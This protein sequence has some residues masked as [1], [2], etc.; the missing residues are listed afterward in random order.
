MFFSCWHTIQ[1]NTKKSLLLHNSERM[2]SSAIDIKRAYFWD[3]CCKL[4]HK[5][6]KI[7]FSM[8]WSNN[9]VKK[10]KK[11]KKTVI[12][13]FQINEIPAGLLWRRNEIH[14][15]PFLLKTFWE[16]FL[17]ASEYFKK[18]II[19]PPPK[20]KF[21]VVSEIFLIHLWLGMILWRTGFHCS[22]TWVLTID[23]SG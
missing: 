6:N 3:P 23:I 10:K 19:I 2:W 12:K 21:T 15:P 8:Y 16:Q 18:L 1:T 14:V 4:K 5:N 11:K 7:R 13:H 17:V 22:V 9:Y 20:K